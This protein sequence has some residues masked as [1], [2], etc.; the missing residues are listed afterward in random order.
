MNFLLVDDDPEDTVLFEE[1]LQEVDHRIRFTAAANGKKALDQLRSNG[2][3]L[4]DLIFLD[5][6]M[7]IMNGKECLAEIKQ[8]TELKKIPVIIY[9]TSSHSKDIEET[10]IGGALC[11]ITKPLNMKD[12]KNILSS[13]VDSMPGNL[14]KAIRGLSNSANTYIV[15]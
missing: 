3:P 5:L 15:Y 8:D 6:N 13:I 12:M 9:T 7:P 14:E 1:V 10:M 11:F 2:Q 4:P